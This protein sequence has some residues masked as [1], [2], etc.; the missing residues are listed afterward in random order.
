[1]DTV[2]YVF[3]VMVVIFLPP[4][5][6]WWF[7]VHPF[8]HFWRRIGPVGTLTV[9]GIIGVLGAI[10]LF[11]IKDR[12]VL[13]DLGTHTSLFVVAAI[14]MTIAI[15]IALQ[16]R[17]YLTKRI[18]SGIPEL[19]KDGKTSVLLKEG[20][21]ARIRHPRYVEIVFGTF[22]YATFA[23]YLGSYL[24]AAL[25]IPVI[26]LIVLLEE[27]ELLDRFGE[28]YARYMAEVPRYVPRRQ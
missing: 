28:E 5:L 16:R 23:N 10:G 19:E 15:R 21:Y 18:L 14:L 12:L 25:T 24:V 4:G 6:V 17:K 2:R 3:A 7:L 13:A 8:V 20:I 9:M 27:R 26:H 1:M 22:A 11:Q